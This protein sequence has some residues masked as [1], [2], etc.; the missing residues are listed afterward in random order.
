MI[1]NKKLLSILALLCLTV[2]SAWA[3]WTGGTYT[4][5]A[6]E[7]LS[8]ITVN[9][10]ATLTINAGVT[11]TVTGVTGINIGQG[12]TVA[13]GKTLTIVG[14][15]TLI[16]YGMK[17][18]DGS[19]GSDGSGGVA[20]ITGDII[21][22]GATVNAIGGAAGN[23][24]NNSAGNGG[25]GAVGGRGLSNGTVTIYYG[26]INATGGTGGNGGNSSA[27]K[28]GDGGE[29]GFGVVVT[30]LNYYGGT[31]N[32]TSGVVGTGG[33]G[34][35]GNG[36]D[37][38]RRKAFG[39]NDVTL[40]NTDATLT[41]DGTNITATTTPT[42]YGYYT[43]NI[44]PNEKAS[45]SCGTSVT[46]SLTSDGVLTISG[47]GAMADCAT[48]NA[49]PWKDN[50]TSITSIV[51]GENVTHI[52]NNAF[53]SCDQATSVSLP[54][55]LMSIGNNAFWGCNNVSLKSITIPNS[56]TS[57]GNKA[58]YGCSNLGTV[59]IGSGVTSIG[60]QAFASCTSL[61]SVTIPNSVTSIDYYA[62]KGCSSL[63]SV[64]LNSNPFIDKEA[65]P[66][67]AAVTMNLTANAADGANWATFY[68]KL[69]SFEAD[70]NTQVFKARLSGTSITLYE[71][72]NRIVDAGT[73]VVLKSTGNP[74]MTLTTEASG[75][76]D[77]NSLEGVSDAAGLTAADPSTTFVLNNGTNGVGF[78]KLKAGKT[79]GVGKAYLTYDSSTAPSF[80]GFGDDAT[81]IKSLTPA[82]SPTGEGSGYFDLQ[83]RRVA[84]PTKG[85]YIVNGK[86]VIIK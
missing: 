9:T 29:G 41:G 4:A 84:Q 6:D 38:T 73:A 12:L 58:F 18:A 44:V 62:F 80:F 37:A 63:T 32:A 75:N 43:V 69:Y 56:V 49:Q 23:G 30:A 86:K 71:V 8:A 77:S 21:V 11:V 7:N 70:E 3:D 51:V 5:T 26:T 10:D 36:S 65:F 79:L 22:K 82:P 39:R 40:M 55:T 68:N 28:G 83:G 24:G 74:V 27:G 54:T 85:L 59:N 35:S 19:D 52:G 64:T 60:S 45:G 13:S 61:T 72:A 25:K 2:T 67:G 66:D 33:T 81:S 57:I 34:T 14:P 17:G 31:V 46:Y 53:G 16:V 20:A 50:R 78:Y 48:S 47:T 76:S 15:G 1:M 42:V